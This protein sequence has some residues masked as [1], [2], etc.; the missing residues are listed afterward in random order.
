MSTATTAYESTQA[1]DLIDADFRLGM[2]MDAP[3]EL[4]PVTFPP[5]S[6][7][8]IVAQAP[9]DVPPA[10]RSKVLP[11]LLAMADSYLRADSLRQALE[12]YFDLSR[13]HPGTPEAEMA[14]ERILEVARR[15]EEAGELHNARAIYERLI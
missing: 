4:T 2:G 5:R 6:K 8:A 1:E 13:S 3:T 15:H 14:E 11:R 7:P 12:M 10:P 9:H